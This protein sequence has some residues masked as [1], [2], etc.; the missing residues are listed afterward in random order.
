M[1]TLLQGSDFSSHRKDLGQ[2]DDN[3]EVFWATGACLF[4]KAKT[5]K[6]YNGFDANFF[7]HMEEI[8]LCWRMKNNN[9]KILYCSESTVYHVGGGT[10]S[11]ASPFK[12]YLN[13]RNSL[14]M[15]HKNHDGW[16]PK[17]IFIRLVLDGI[18]GVKFLLGGEF[19]S[20]LSIIKAHFHYYAHIK[21]LNKQRKKLTSEKFQKIRRCLR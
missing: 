12:T 4:I 17:I 6:A 21:T 5:F 19:K 16:L 7:A 10:L 14:F 15:I 2:F 3:K 8:D 9:E 13:F 11:Y 1:V 18:A 20:F